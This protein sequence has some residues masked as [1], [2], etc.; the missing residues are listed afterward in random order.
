MQKGWHLS[1]IR[2]G[3]LDR[4][5]VLSQR[6][7]DNDAWNDGFVT[8]GASAFIG[9]W[10]EFVSERRCHAHHF[11]C[12]CGRNPFGTFP[13]TWMQLWSRR[14]P[15]PT[16][17]AS[18]HSEDQQ[19]GPWPQPGNLTKASLLWWLRVMIF[20]VEVAARAFSSVASYVAW[21]LWASAVVQHS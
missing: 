15:T 6:S 2:A 16:P 1:I 9:P 14:L 19:A 3:H 13:V 4:D 8:W 5:L 18:Q 12:C 7:L 21:S 17:L 20:L 11:W 10:G